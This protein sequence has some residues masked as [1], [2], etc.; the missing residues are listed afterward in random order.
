MSEGMHAAWT[1]VGLRIDIVPNARTK[2]GDTPSSGK[3]DI[4]DGMV[5]RQNI[6]TRRLLFV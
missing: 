2:G 1:G 6:L 5:K 4:S 3:L